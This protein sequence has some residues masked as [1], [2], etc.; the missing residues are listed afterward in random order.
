MERSLFT[1]N[2]ETLGLMDRKEQAEATKSIIL[3]H[4]HAE[5]AENRSNGDESATCVT[6]KEAACSPWKVFIS[7][8]ITIFLAEIGDKTQVSTLLMSAEFHNPWVVFAGAGT[9]LVTTT[10]LG[11][12]VGRWLSTRLSPRTLDIAAGILLA[13][14]SVGLII[15]VIQM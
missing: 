14:I 1:S 12:L 10:L 3:E 13:L 11:V 15:D 7:T 4:T 8:F 2:Q 6:G 9:A 5:L